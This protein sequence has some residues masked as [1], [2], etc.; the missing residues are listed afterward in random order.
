MRVFISDMDLYVLKTKIF[1]YFST[2]RN[3]K[4]TYFLTRIKNALRNMYYLKIRNG[5]FV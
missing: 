2:K 4:N 1:K 5:I 3:I